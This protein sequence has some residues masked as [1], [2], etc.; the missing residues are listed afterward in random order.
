[1]GIENQMENWV[2]GFLNWWEKEEI[3][4]KERLEGREGM[5]EIGKNKVKYGLE[6]EK[7]L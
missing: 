5:K 7:S 3:E 4:E 1:M 6:H 2:Y